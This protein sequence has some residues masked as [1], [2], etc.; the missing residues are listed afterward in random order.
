[1]MN[2]NQME[3]LAGAAKHLGAE[4]I[5]AN[6]VVALARKYWWASLPVT[7]MVYGRI[8][9][10]MEREKKMKLHHYL[11][12]TTE[13]VGPVLTIVGIFELASRMKQEGKLDDVIK[14]KQQMVAQQ[15][16]PQQALQG[17][18]HTQETPPPHLQR[19]M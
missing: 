14:P 2:R 5:L 4:G 7:F 15:Q 8:R 11:V 17:P 19:G 3:M 16:P 6:P 18:S 1:M 12:E 9:D 10:R 13:V